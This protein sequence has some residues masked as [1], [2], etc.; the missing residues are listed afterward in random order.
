MPAPTSALHRV[1]PG[2][3]VDL[4]AVD[5]R[6]ASAAPGDRKVTEPATAQLQHRLAEL[7]DVLWAQG[8]HRVLV[9]L[10]GTDTSGKGGAIKALLRELNPSGIEVATFK[11]PTEP[12][13]NRDYLWRVHQQVPASGQLVVFDRSHY[14]DVLIVR[15]KG[16]VEEDRWRRRFDH[17][18]DFERMLVE[19][20][21]LIVKLFLHISKDEQRERL[22]ARLDD[23]TK[24]WKF[25]PGDL[26]ERERW[27]GYQEAYT[28]VIERTSTSWAPWYVIPADRKWYRNWAACSIVADAL[29]T[30][31][32]AYPPAY[33]GA[34]EVQ[35]R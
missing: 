30:L 20:G 2:A 5:P 16:L 17:I 28:E 29:A 35:V 14:E 11:A 8:E 25:L 24:R 9:I 15:V 21:T 1:D 3:R 22:Q 31:D 34:H 23:P 6:D 33:P 27:D 7:H 18:N 26:E 32:L 12:E 10:Q 19:E 4:A 13:L